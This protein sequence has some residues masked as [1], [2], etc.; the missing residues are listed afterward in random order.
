MEVVAKPR[1]IHILVLVQTYTQDKTVSI[2]EELL[3]ELCS[4]V[5]WHYYSSA[6]CCF[7]YFIVVAVTEE[8][9]VVLVVV[10]RLRAHRQVAAFTNLIQQKFSKTKQHM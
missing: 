6:Y 7:S 2:Q 9:V 8:D 1:I 10:D 4:E 3:L 5:S